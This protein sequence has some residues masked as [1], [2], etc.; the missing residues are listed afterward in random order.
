MR[1]TFKGL[2]SILQDKVTLTVDLNH[3][4]LK[5]ELDLLSPEKIYF[6]MMIYVIACLA[7]SDL[8]K[9]VAG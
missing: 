4:D 1:F 5:I 7:F 6:Q 9:V 8:S 3:L 2:F